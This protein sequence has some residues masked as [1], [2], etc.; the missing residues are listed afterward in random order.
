MGK[1]YIRVHEESLYKSLKF[2]CVC[3]LGSR[4]KKL[5]CFLAFESTAVQFF[6]SQAKY[7]TVLLRFR[8]FCIKGQFRVEQIYTKQLVQ[9][10]ALVSCR[11][12][13]LHKIRLKLPQSSF[14]DTHEIYVL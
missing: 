12:D 1:N 3:D 11:V 8:F 13:K 2:C 9:K 7:H 10:I 6:I 5:S 14:F 4:Y